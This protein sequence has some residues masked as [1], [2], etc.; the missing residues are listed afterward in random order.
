[1]GSGLWLF[2]S[3][4]KE[5]LPETRLCD[6]FNKQLHIWV[7]ALLHHSF[8]YTLL[9]ALFRVKN[10]L[11]ILS[12][13]HPTFPLTLRIRDWKVVDLRRVL[14]IGPLRHQLFTQ[15]VVNSPLADSLTLAQLPHAVIWDDLTLVLR[16]RG[17]EIEKTH[18]SGEIYEL[19]DDVSVHIIVLIVKQGTKWE[20]P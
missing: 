12:K 15:C 10:R 1:M 7:F 6:A 11:R 19:I 16:E 2:R 14:V 18:C 4:C 17:E 3:W 8:I 9:R 13:S 5:E 20:F